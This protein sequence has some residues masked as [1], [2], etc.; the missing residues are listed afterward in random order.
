MM[1]HK[2]AAFGIICC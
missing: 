1:L 2:M